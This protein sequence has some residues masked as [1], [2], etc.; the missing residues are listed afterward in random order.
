MSGKGCKSCVSYLKEEEELYDYIKSI[1][2]G[3]IKRHDRSVLNGLELDIF[4]ADKN[5]AFEFDGLYWHCELQKD[6]KYHLNKTEQCLEK[7]IRLIH[8]FEDEWNNKKDICKSRIRN[9]LGLTKNIIYARKCMIKYVDSKTSNN[10]LSLNHIQSSAN[11]NINI[12]LYYNDELVSLMTFSK[13]RKILGRKSVN[14]E[15][16]LLRFC[17]KIDLIVVGGASKLF[18]FFLKEYNP[19]KVISYADR[20]WSVG[21]LYEKLDFKLLHKS[22]PSYFYIFNN[23]RVNRYTFRKDIL[24]KKYGCSEDDTEHSFCLKNKWYRI[25]DCGTLVFQ[26]LKK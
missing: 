14:N 11:S 21:N 16:E 13:L 12:G 18:S 17:N 4:I 22:K 24:V 8:I 7:G 10:F 1:Y 6:S 26:Y 23:K 5:L 9:I 19:N 3:E 20:R 2:K 15:F 25:Y